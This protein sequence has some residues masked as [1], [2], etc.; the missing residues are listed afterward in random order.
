[1]AALVT[2]NGVEAG[3]ARELATLAQ[4]RYGR[5]QQLLRDPSL[6][7]LRETTQADIERLLTAG[8]N[9]RFD[10]ARTLSAPW[11]RERESVL[12]TLEGGRGWWREALRGAAGLDATRLTPRAAA[13]ALRAVQTAREHL[14]DNTNPQLALEVLML[15]LPQL[16]A[17]AA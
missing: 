2:R 14:L 5:A 13:E 6:G 4:G 15:D 11:S 16:A 12:A 3:A 1:A 7:V 8:R 9:E 17:V 10:Y